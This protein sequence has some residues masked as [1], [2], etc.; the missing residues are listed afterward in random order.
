MTKKTRLS[1]ITMTL[2]V[3]GTLFLMLVYSYFL[4]YISDQAGLI[5]KII[6]GIVVFVSAV[7]IIDFVFFE[8]KNNGK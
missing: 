1:L 3:F 4:L 2:L 6:M 8:V 5:G 7:V